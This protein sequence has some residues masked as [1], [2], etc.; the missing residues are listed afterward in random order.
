MRVQISTKITPEFLKEL[1]KECMEA[2]ERRRPIEIPLPPSN[3]NESQLLSICG[4]VQRKKM[5]G[6]KR[7]ALNTTNPITKAY[8]L[9]LRSQI[10]G[11]IAR[12]FYS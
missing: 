4:G 2:E 3:Q 8:I 5:E 6:L 1:Q 10:D 9:E 7:K 12:A 11:K